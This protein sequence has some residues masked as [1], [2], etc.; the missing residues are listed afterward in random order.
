M[1]WIKFTEREVDLFTAS[2]IAI[3]YTVYLKKYLG[4]NFKAILL[5]YKH[6]VVNS[7][8][9]ENDYKKVLSLTKDKSKFVSILNELEKRNKILRRYIGLKDRDLSKLSDSDFK[10]FFMIFSRSYC[11]YFPLFVL[12]RYFGLMLNFEDLPRK[13]YDKLIRLR[14]TS[15]SELIQEK[16]LPLLF[17]EIQ[18]RKKIKSQLLF[19]AFP[20]EIESLL[21]DRG[22][23]SNA[24]LERRSKYCA[25]LIKRNKFFVYYG[26][27]ARKIELSASSSVLERL[28]REIS[29]K[30]AYGRGILRG[31]VKLVVRRNDIKNA[32]GLILVTPMI[33]I[34]FKPF[35]KKVLAIVTDE[36]GIGCHAAII[37]REFKIPCIVGTR[38]ASKVLKDGDFVEINMDKGIIR[39]L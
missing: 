13:T 38:I 12:P 39:K 14:G 28:P 21:S 17:G 9:E 15:M 5:I 35:L 29:G 27:K 24:I 19:Y 30:T 31:R 3:G 18:H 26:R 16:F 22:T 11:E 36:G 7:H 33:Q 32:G 23:I 2:S 8:R 34:R 20:K 25:V 10:N 37:S 1:K 6:D 4:V